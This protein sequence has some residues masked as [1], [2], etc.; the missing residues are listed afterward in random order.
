MPDENEQK[1][2][3][4]KIS[5]RI[6]NAQV[7]LEGTN[8]NI[9]KLMGKELVD[10]TKGLEETTKQLPSSTEIA[11]KITPKAPEVTPKEKTMLPPSKPSTTPEPLIK[12]PPVSTIGKPTEKM[13]KKRIVSRNAVIALAL[14]LILLASLVSVIA[15]YVPM[16]SDLE[17]QI[18]EKDATISSLNS[19]VAALQ[20]TLGQV[21]NEITTKDSQIAALNSTVASYNSAILDY[22]EI[23]SLQA[24]GLLYNQEITQDASNYTVIWNNP[25]EYAGYVT[26]VVQS[27]SNTTYVEPLYSSYGVNFDYNMT[28]GTSGTAAFPVLPGLVEIRVGNTELAGTIT[29]AITATY[30]Y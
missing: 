7:E 10:F 25:V 5:I 23:L 30:F 26:V 8:E 21:A 29:A 1:K 13:V 20:S 19:Q 9:K 11:P 4:S 15:I 16:V 2:E 6:G 3:R 17:S 28:V 24:S 22:R 18:A 14:V 12:S 27:S